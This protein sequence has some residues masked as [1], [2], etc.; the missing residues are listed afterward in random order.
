[1]KFEEILIHRIR[2]FDA[3]FRASRKADLLYY[4]CLRQLAKI[5]GIQEK[6]IISLVKNN[7]LNLFGYQ[8]LTRK[9]TLDFVFFSKFYEPETTAYMRS[10]KGNVLFDIGSHLGRFSIINSGNFKKIYSVE[11]Q[12]ENF[13]YLEKNIRLNKIKNIIP[14]NVAVSDRE[15]KVNISDLNINTGV[16]TISEKG[17]ETAAKTLDGLIKDFRIPIH[18]VNI[19][20]IDVEG[21]EINVLK[22]AKNLLKKEA[23]IIVMESFAI[24]EVKNFL[25]KFGFTYRKTLDFYNHLFV[26]RRSN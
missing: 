1:M 19:I 10:M 9:E 23:P 20:K 25:G 15:G 17:K 12:A 5:L 22:G 6:N 7:K 21:H 11:P 26:K 8:F 16:V 14:L 24:E 4:V 2:D 13:Q 18:D 3:A